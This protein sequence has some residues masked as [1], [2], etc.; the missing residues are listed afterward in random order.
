MQF[1]LLGKCPHLGLPLS[2]IRVCGTPSELHSV[3]FVQCVATQNTGF[4]GTLLPLSSK[5][6]SLFSKHRGSQPRLQLEACEMCRSHKLSPNLLLMWT[7]A[8]QDVRSMPASGWASQV[9]H[10]PGWAALH[11]QTANLLKVL[12]VAL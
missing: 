3:L 6:Q 8:E 12:C 5:T 11:F 10:D 2:K 9:F 4:G 7:D 1:K